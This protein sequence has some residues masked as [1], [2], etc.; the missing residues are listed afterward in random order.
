M[1]ATSTSVGSAGIQPDLRTFVGAVDL[2]VKTL[3]SANAAFSTPKSM[4]AGGTQPIHLVLPAESI[5]AELR[6]ALS[7]S[8]TKLLQRP[9]IGDRIEARLDGDANFQV[10]PMTLEEHSIEWGE[11][12]RWLWQITPLRP[13]MHDL[14]LTISVLLD[15]QGKPMR[16]TEVFHRRISVEVVPWHARAVDFAKD[17]WQ[18]L[19]AS[20]IVPFVG[21]FWGGSNRTA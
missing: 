6:R 10:I 13:G 12:T 1:L 19:W 9:R 16:R 21:W 17:H 11:E 8:G 2:I 14:N 4:T 15:V 7:P 5:P 3:G 20:L 18:W